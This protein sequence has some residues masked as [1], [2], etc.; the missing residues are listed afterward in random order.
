[1]TCGTVDLRG[2]DFQVFNEGKK[3]EKKEVIMPRTMLYYTI[4]ISSQARDEA[5]K[6]KMKKKNKRSEAPRF[7]ILPYLQ[8]V[9][10][11][12]KKGT[13]STATKMRPS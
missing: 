2:R 5:A 8:T 7:N 13:H 3:R 12:P 9:S 10:C 1:M 4:G 11:H 6:T